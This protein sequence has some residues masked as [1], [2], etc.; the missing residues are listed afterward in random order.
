MNDTLSPAELLSLTESAG[1]NN[2]IDA[3]LSAVEL[4]G[5]WEPVLASWEELGG[6]AAAF[7]DVWALSLVLHA[8]A[9][10]FATFMQV[11]TDQVI[12]FTAAVQGWALSEHAHLA[13]DA[14]RDLTA[15]LAGAYEL[16]ATD[17]L[18]DEAASLAAFWRERSAGF[19]R[20]ALKVGVTEDQP[21]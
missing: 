7:A 16:I 6:R 5:G 9:E 19:A 14:L 11:E 20:G 10:T 17:Q 3:L 2:A 1:S 8:E 21:Q 4:A 15:S 18:G 13:E 12:G